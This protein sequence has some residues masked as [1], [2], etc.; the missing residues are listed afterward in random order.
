MDQLKLIAFDTEDL[1]ILSA[2]LQDAVV[3]VA[4]MTYRPRE[5]RFA[6]VLNRFDW[7]QALA[8]EREL[9]RR[10]SALRFERVRSARTTG[11]D[12][13]RPTDVLALLA[14]SFAPAGPDDAAGTVTLTFAGSA[15]IQLE[16]E[17]LEAELR[18]L[19]PAWKARGQPDHSADDG[20][21]TTG[22]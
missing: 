11:I 18:D 22:G 20:S 16:V 17:C 2:H 5:R 13:Q 6:A 4:D 7:A 9:L 19:G 8:G 21:G 15:A 3:R 14:V 12:R 10:Q 1:G